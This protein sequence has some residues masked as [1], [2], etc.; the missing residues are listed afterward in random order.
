MRGHR[1]WRAQRPYKLQK[2][3]P[4]AW[5]RPLGMRASEDELSEQEVLQ[6]LYGGGGVPAG[7]RAKKSK[8]GMYTGERRGRGR[9]KGMGWPPPPFD[10]FGDE[11]RVISTGTRSVMLPAEVPEFERSVWNRVRKVIIQS[12]D[13]KAPKRY[14]A[15]RAAKAHYDT[16]IPRQRGRPQAKKAMKWAKARYD[17]EMRFHN[18]GIHRDMT[19]QQLWKVLPRGL[20]VS[21]ENIDAVASLLGE[22]TKTVKG[23]AFKVMTGVM[24]LSP[25]TEAGF[26][27]CKGASKGCAAVCLGHA[28]GQ[29]RT[30]VMQKRR[31]RKTLYFLIFRRAFIHHLTQE[32]NQLLGDAVSKGYTPAIR[33]NGSSD[34]EWERP[35]YGSIPQLFSGVQM[36][37]YTKLPFSDRKKAVALPNYHLTYS[38]SERRD[39]LKESLAYLKA[40]ANVAVVVGAE[41]VFKEGANKPSTRWHIDAAKA[42]LDRGTLAG[43]PVIDGD[44][45][46]IRFDDP[47]GSWV[48]LYAKGAAGTDQSGFVLRLTPDGFPLNPRFSAEA[49]RYRRLPLAG[50][51]A[52]R[53]RGRRKESGGA[54]KISELER[55]YW[56]SMNFPDC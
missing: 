39:S 25:F 14:E 44:K 43:Y 29:L 38:Y 56:E 18:A 12:E 20:N 33:L 27:I 22:S 19:P 46:D 49:R 7:L 1:A 16:F 15:Y 42:L 4:A 47:P 52:R 41:G 48:V 54:R 26:N 30:S 6:A 50:A 10:S 21:G 55:W 31:I 11:V 9:G 34:I 2:R 37:D 24:Y 51:A 53:R 3:L 45:S 36:Y 5:E 13:I 8:T 40:G 28:S 35:E 23:Y 32:I 17:Y